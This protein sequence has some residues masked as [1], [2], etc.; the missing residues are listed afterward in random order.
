MR[1]NIQG[2]ESATFTNGLGETIELVINDSQAHTAELLLKILNGDSAAAELLA[3][4]VHKSVICEHANI[5]LLP[6][7][8]IQ[9]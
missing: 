9:F 8:V 4:E 2:E 5:E 3:D 1:D 6:D 7:L